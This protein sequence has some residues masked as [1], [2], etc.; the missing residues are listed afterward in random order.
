MFHGAWEL[1]FFRFCVI[2]LTSGEF[3][4]PSPH[5]NQ[6][7][8]EPAALTGPLEKFWPSGRFLSL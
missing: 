7:K 4:Q 2:S 8:A 1:L 6:V 3:L 5:S